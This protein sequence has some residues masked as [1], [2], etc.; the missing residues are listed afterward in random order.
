MNSRPAGIK[1]CYTYDCS[2]CVI[3][4]RQLLGAR[5]KKAHYPTPYNTKSTNTNWIISDWMD[6]VHRSNG[7]LSHSIQLAFDGKWN[8][9][10]MNFSVVSSGMDR[11]DCETCKMNKPF[12]HFI[13]ARIKMIH[14]RIKSV[15][16]TI[17]PRVFSKMKLISSGVCGV[18]TQ[19]VDSIAIDILE[20]WL[21]ANI[22]ICIHVAC[23][24]FTKLNFI[25]TFNNL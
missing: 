7:T 13:E 8:L 4:V 19:L 5:E 20:R 14:L 16:L 15:P 11:C 18:C 17:Q 25:I 9:S 12:G 2:S 23:T 21:R 10:Q 3:N 6:I 22:Y 1:S 24:C